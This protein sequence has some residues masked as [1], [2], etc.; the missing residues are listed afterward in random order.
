MFH[1]MTIDR[2]AQG[3]WICSDNANLL[4]PVSTPSSG[5]I[6]ANDLQIASMK[7]GE[8][9]HLFSSWMQYFLVQKEGDK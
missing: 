3:L 8:L 1:K 9:W 2:N 6:S 7:G 5:W 4:D